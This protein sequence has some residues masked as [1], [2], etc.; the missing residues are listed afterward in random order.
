[1]E[2]AKFNTQLLFNYQ[3]WSNTMQGKQILDSATIFVPPQHKQY[4]LNRIQDTFIAGARAQKEI[5]IELIKKG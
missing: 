3:V 4:F 1:M 2:E 5:D